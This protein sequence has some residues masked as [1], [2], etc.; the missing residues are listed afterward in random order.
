MGT[1]RLSSGALPLAL[2]VLGCSSLPEAEPARGGFSP[3]GPA[4]RLLGAEG[5]EAGASE[6]EVSLPLPWW[7][8][9]G[10]G[11]EGGLYVF[12]PGNFRS[13]VGDGE[14]RG[15]R[16]G[17]EW[18]LNGGFELAVGKLEAP[19]T[20][21]ENLVSIPVRATFLMGGEFG[22]GLLAWHLGL[23][24]GY[25]FTEDRPEPGME[26]LWP[27]DLPY[28][29][30]EFTYHVTLGFEFRTGD[31]RMATRLEAGHAWMYETG[32]DHW[33]QSLTLFFLF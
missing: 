12:R 21:L 16:Y 20:G 22:T 23:G 9:G 31:G 32:A 27:P 1:L 7:R 5:G 24:A 29:K 8:G 26:L 30:S 4:A 2:L 33:M 14:Y 15:V 17:R 19:V 28:L 25:N 10:V 18:G 11:V 13:W 6:P 3:G